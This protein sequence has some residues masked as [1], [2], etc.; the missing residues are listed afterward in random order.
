[1]VM[2]DRNQRRT[3]FPVRYVCLLVPLGEQS[4]GSKTKCVLSSTWELVSLSGIHCGGSPDQEGGFGEMA[5]RNF[6]DT[7]NADPARLALLSEC[8]WTL[9]GPYLGVFQMHSW[10]LLGTKWPAY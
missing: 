1:M 2:C 7:S 5:P 3:G 8:D 6:Q 4:K 10:T 9:G